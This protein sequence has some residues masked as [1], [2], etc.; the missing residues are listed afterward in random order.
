MHTIACYSTY[1][2]S[3]KTA[4][5][6]PGTAQHQPQHPFLQHTAEPAQCSIREAQMPARHVRPS[7]Q[8]A[9]PTHQSSAQSRSRGTGKPDQAGHSHHCKLQSPSTQLATGEAPGNPLPAAQ[10]SKQANTQQPPQHRH[11]QPATGAGAG[12]INALHMG[13]SSSAA[14]GSS[15]VLTQPRAAWRPPWLLLVLLLLV[16]PRAHP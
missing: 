15:A 3:H 16:R 8:G 13:S 10:T 7:V 12:Q 9:R 6:T 11:S 1:L 2:F 14:G 4:S 5:V